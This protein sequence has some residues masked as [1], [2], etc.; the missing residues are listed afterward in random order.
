[1][2]LFR[3][4]DDDHH[5]NYSDLIDENCSLLLGS[6]LQ[7]PSIRQLFSSFPGTFKG[8]IPFRRENFYDSYIMN[9]LHNIQASF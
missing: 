8:E 7:S 5:Y 9:P 3:K 2:K 4:K 6:P 1:M